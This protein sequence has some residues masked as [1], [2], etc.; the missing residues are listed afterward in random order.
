MIYFFLKA[1]DFLP[2]KQPRFTELVFKQPR[3]T[4]LVFKQ[5]RFTELVFKQPRFTELVFK[6]PRFTEL[7]F[8]QPRFIEFAARVR[9]KSIGNLIYCPRVSDVIKTR[10][11]PAYSILFYIKRFL[12]DDSER[13]FG[14]DRNYI[15][16]MSFVVYFPFEIRGSFP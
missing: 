15:S 5:P 6:Q 14:F 1:N 10:T 4:E 13:I 11:R 16:I 2:F 3:F 7:V 12:S 9:I 8:K